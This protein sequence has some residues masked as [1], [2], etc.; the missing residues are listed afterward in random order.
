MSQTK[1]KLAKELGLLEA[2]AVATGG[3]VSAGLF[4]L[5][6]LV[7]LDAGP[8]LTLCYLL[9]VIPLIPPTLSLLELSTAM[10][11]A[12]GPYYFIDRSL[13][14]L[15]GTVG[16]IGT[17]LSLVL[18]TTV[19][20]VGI[21]IYLNLVFPDMPDWAAN[22]AAVSGAMFLGVLN[23][24]GAR[25]SGTLQILLVAG[26]ILFSTAFI[27]IGL[28]EVQ[29]SNFAGMG[30]V[31]PEA[32]LAAT[33]TTF[34]SYGGL[35]AIAGVA[36]E[37]E[38]PERVLPRAIFLALLTAVLVY[39]L[40]TFVIQ[41]VV[42]MEQLAGNKH[43]PATAADLLVGRVGVIAM[44]VA[45]LLAFFSVG[46]AGVMSGSRYPLA[47][48]RDKL[49]PP[50]FGALA[51]NGAPRF[52]V[53]LTVGTMIAVILFLD[54]LDIAKL[55]SAFLLLVFAILCAAVI[56]WRESGIESYDPGY[57]S[58][59][60]PYMHI[61]GL[62]FPFVLIGQMGWL[63]TVFSAAVTGASLMWYFYYAKERAE[64]R[65]ALFH[66]FAR[67]GETR[68]EDL[69]SELREILKEKGL[70]ENDPFDEI[71]LEAIVI[72]VEE[73]DDF[74]AL[75]EHAS[76]QLAETLGRPEALFVDGFKEGTA[77]GATPVAKGIALPHMRIPDLAKPQ[78]VLARTR[79]E[80]RVHTGD[81]FGS[82]MTF[83][84][85][86]AVFFLVSPEDDPAQHLRMLAQ[87][88]QRI[89]RDDFLPAWL[90][91]QNEVRLREVFLRD[92]RYISL[93]L[94]H[95]E[96]AY[97]LVGRALK[98]LGLPTG[99]LVAAVRRQGGTIVP[100]GGT[101]LEEEDRVL[102]I[103]EPDAITQ[104]Y[105]RYAHGSPAIDEPSEG[106]A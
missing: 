44:T 2:Y 73:V 59:F 30:S 90:A 102:I 61:F 29:L 46:N 94:H 72:D 85:V 39:G 84:K 34:M 6:G 103:G 12:G 91:A 70:R 77:T 18:K 51:K 24:A 14:P 36:E 63:P 23:A 65:G 64:R 88:A 100:S 60:Y 48:S 19:A 49:L 33:G 50:R 78:M 69:D 79:R 10:P 101:V 96:A 15:F 43:A 7:A 11:R 20:F 93:L 74:D 55:A 21:G 87:L 16:G 95:D 22:V 97:E 3:T 83:D 52:A 26:L 5:P 98:D 8:A 76:A 37:I 68:H 42:P 105:A 80:I 81:V 41:G 71:V 38:D 4:I 35:S 45:A 75:I 66:V 86:H 13:G 104:L 106:A 92:E 57:R 99:S 1:T 58:P 28:P 82:P 17:W 53:Y 31:G 47:M 54:A 62:V 9:A 32:I 56:V 67:L 25:T 40:A 27:A 89:D